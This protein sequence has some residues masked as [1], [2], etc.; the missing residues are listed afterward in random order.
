M[1]TILSVW[2]EQILLQQEQPDSGEE[3]LQKQAKMQRELEEIL[4]RDEATLLSLYRMGARFNLLEEPHK[5]AASKLFIIVLV[6]Q[7]IISQIPTLLGYPFG[8]NTMLFYGLNLPFLILLFLALYLVK[9]R[10]YLV[11]YLSFLGILA[12]LMNLQFSMTGT[13]EAQTKILALIHLPLLLVV[14]LALPTQKGSLQERMSRHIRLTGEVL[15]LTF[16]LACAV[17]VVTMLTFVLFEAVGVNVEDR[18]APFVVTGI[19]ALLPLSARYLLQY[20][21]GQIAS[22]T[23]LLA[24]IFLPVITVVMISFLGALVIGRLPI[25]EDRNLLLVIDILLALVLMMILYATDLLESEQTT[26]FYRIV[27]ITAALAAIG[28]DVFALIAIGGRFLQYGLSPNRLAVLAENLLLLANLGSLA[29]TLLRRRSFIRIQSIFMVIY[30]LWF[31]IVV[32]LFGPL[33]GY[34]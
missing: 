14:S 25:T 12:L 29:V 20:R 10:K 3:K 6:S 8:D 13:E 21:R 24:T 15:L 5:R 18:L 23:R 22:L 4:P 34:M 32:L 7:L 11:G 1:K 27:L 19:L 9:E 17:F 16:L 31:L 30:A 2:K 26:P 28:I 33:F